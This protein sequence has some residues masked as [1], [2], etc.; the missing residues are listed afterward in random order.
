MTNQNVELNYDCY[1][2]IFNKCNLRTLTQISW[3]VEEHCYFGAKDPSKRLTPYEIEV[4]RMAG[5]IHWRNSRGAR[6]RDGDDE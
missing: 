1:E 4:Y 2:I 5:H 6:I 3:I